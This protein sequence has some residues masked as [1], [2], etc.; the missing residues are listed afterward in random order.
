MRYKNFNYYSFKQ[1]TGHRTY[2]IPALKR[3]A[4]SI[5]EVKKIINQ[6]L[7]MKG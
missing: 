4:F 5:K 6:H 1:E 7:E 2:T 3:V